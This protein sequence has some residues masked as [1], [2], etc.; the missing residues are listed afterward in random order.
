MIFLSVESIVAYKTF[1]II[2]NQMALSKS[3]GSSLGVHHYRCN[4]HLSKLEK[5]SHL[6]QE[7]DCR[8]HI[9]ITQHSRYQIL[10]P[11]PPRVRGIGIGDYYSLK[12]RQIGPS[13][14]GNAQ[15][16]TWFAIFCHPQLL[17]YETLVAQWVPLLGCLLMRARLIPR[18][19]NNTYPF[20]IIHI[21]GLITCLPVSSRWRAVRTVALEQHP[22]NKEARAIQ[23][24]QSTMAQDIS[25]K[26]RTHLRATGPQH[27]R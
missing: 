4:L 19:S 16:F 22:K 2:Q 7:S 23:S 15:V 26:F 14:S 12:E 9:L 27:R 21:P 3:R 6:M 10:G 25:G 17:D 24:I 20:R 11:K 8:L 13:N 18:S 1:S 5:A